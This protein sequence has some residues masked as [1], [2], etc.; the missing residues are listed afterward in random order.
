MIISETKLKSNPHASSFED[1][2]RKFSLA[3]AKL[4]RIDIKR[5]HSSCA[6]GAI[7]T[8]EDK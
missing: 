4:K 6:K 5:L 3:K 2:I 8:T 1:K 7:Q